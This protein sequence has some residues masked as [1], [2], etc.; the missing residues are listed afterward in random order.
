MYGRQA[1]LPVDVI[2]GTV[3]P[4]SHQSPNEYAANLDKQLKSA[5][6]L[7][8]KTAG[9]QRERQKQYYDQKVHGTSYNP[10][11]L[12][13]LLNPKVPK[14]SSKKLFHPWIGPF[15][16]LKQLSE[17]TYRVQKLEGKRNRQVVHFNRLKPCPVDIRLNTDNQPAQTPTPDNYV[18]EKPQQRHP[19]SS[20]VGTHL[21]LID[22]DDD[23]MAVNHPTA[24]TPPHQP[25]QQRRNPP[26][27][28]HPPVRL[29]DYV[30]S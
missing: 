23:E 16:I 24:I 2:Y 6:D 10:G 14:N 13:W 28:R 20:P 5:F 26:Q 22:G 29:Q 30:R 15:K 1:R 25:M 17:C 21:E 19:Q 7:A 18:M 12:V 4:D 11:D 27:Q 3:R 9:V 8:R